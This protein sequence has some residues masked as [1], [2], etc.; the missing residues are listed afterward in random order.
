MVELS[1]HSHNTERCSSYSGIEMHSTDFYLNLTL[2]C[3]LRNFLT[4]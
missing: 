2:P 3:I 1:F 4:A